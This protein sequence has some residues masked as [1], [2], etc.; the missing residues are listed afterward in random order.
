MREILR[1]RHSTSS[2]GSTQPKST[3]SPE[4]E[5]SQSSGAEKNH[6]LPLSKSTVEVNPF[7]QK[8][9]DGRAKVKSKNRKRGKKSNQRTDSRPNVSE[10]E[11]RRS[12]SH[13]AIA[14]IL[15]LSPL[16]SLPRPHSLSDNF[17][18]IISIISNDPPFPR[19]ESIP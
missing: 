4:R 16:Q 17:G 2:R 6:F 12:D 3:I 19:F 15:L 5:S 7:V 9:R 18:S 10:S 11:T 14:I 8:T 1:A 13:S